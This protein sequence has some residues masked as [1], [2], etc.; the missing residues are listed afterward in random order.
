M[1]GEL[2]KEPG[3]EDFFAA[4]RVSCA[5]CKRIKAGTS[6]KLLACACCKAVWYC[7]KA[8]EVAHWKAEHKHVCVPVDPIP[9][10]AP[11]PA[12]APAAPA[13][14]PA[15]AP[16]RQGREQ[17]HD[18]TPGNPWTTLYA[19]KA[20]EALREAGV[21]AQAGAWRQCADKYLEATTLAPRTWEQR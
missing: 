21:A 2:A 12:P 11:P 17:R 14:A 10:P 20:A 15:S 8:C 9:A 1:R 16:P 18:T 6:A 7:G 3:G 4:Q 13:P 19:A 5:F